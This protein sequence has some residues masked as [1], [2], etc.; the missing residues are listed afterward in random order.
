MTKDTG[1]LNL[2]NGNVKTLNK[3]IYFWYFCINSLLLITYIEYVIYSFLGLWLHEL[4]DKNIHDYIERRL[5]YQ[6]SCKSGN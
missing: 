2:P 6:E 3:K 1:L 4:N 5:L